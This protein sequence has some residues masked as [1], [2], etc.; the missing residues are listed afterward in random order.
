MGSKAREPRVAAIH[1]QR[2]L[3]GWCCLFEK[4]VDSCRECT[5]RQ[6]DGPLNRDQ[7]MNIAGARLIHQLLVCAA[8]EEKEGTAHGTRHQSR[9]ICL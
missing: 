6:T 9:V 7:G 8:R 1:Y 4:H 3:E 5:G 2:M